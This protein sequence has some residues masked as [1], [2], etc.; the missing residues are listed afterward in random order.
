MFRSTFRAALL[1]ALSLTAAATASAG[2]F[3]PRAD[4]EALAGTYASTAPEPWYGG[5]GTRSFS[6]ERGTWGL[7]FVH[8]L[9]EG[10]T[11][12]TFQFRTKGP[13]SVGAPS[14]AVSGAFE[15]VFVEEVKYVTLLTADPAIVNAFGFAGCGLALNVEVD[16]SKTGCAGWKPVSVCREDHDLLAIDGKGL[17]FG[18]RPRDNDMCTPDKRPTALLPPVARR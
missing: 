5:Y 9:D 15:A 6:F 17:Y 8:A 12:R 14:K 10:M 16:I 2:G 13:Y 4:L 7:T 11:K 18:V 1:A 3:G